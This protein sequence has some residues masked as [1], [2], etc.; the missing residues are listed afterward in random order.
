MFFA[1]AIIFA[2]ETLRC[3]TRV[4]SDCPNTR[5]MMGPVLER[6]DEAATEADG[7]HGTRQPLRLELLQV[8]QQGLSSW[9]S[10]VASGWSIWAHDWNPPHPQPQ[11]RRGVVEVEL[12]L[13][14]A[15]GVVGE[16]QVDVLQLHVT[17]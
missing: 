3:A 10:S 9:V 5:R 1:R 4:G 6:L 13:L 16:C 17:T 14:P 15:G 7:H 2:L 12:P 11:R 8:V